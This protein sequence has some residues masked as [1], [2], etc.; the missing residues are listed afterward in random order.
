MC[1]LL[2][3]PACCNDYTTT[4]SCPRCC[5]H[6]LQVTKVVSAGSDGSALHFTQNWDETA[7]DPVVSFSMHQQI[8]TRVMALHFPSDCA[9]FAEA[10]FSIPFDGHILFAMCDKHYKLIQPE[11]WVPIRN[12]F[13]QAGIPAFGSYEL[14]GVWLTQSLQLP[15]GTVLLPGTSLHQVGFDKCCSQVDNT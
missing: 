6:V 9:L 8:H 10:R 3:S 15:S 14:K 7:V 13:V 2:T 5:S 4:N 1:L 12:L 11:R